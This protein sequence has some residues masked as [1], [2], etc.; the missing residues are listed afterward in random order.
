MAR[1]N[2]LS[3]IAS[4]IDGFNGGYDTV[5]KV[6]R[7]RD[8]RQVA[9]AKPDES[10]GMLQEGDQ[11][12]VQAQLDSGAGVGEARTLASTGRA[13]STFS[14]LGQ[15]Q[16]TPF[17][18][19]QEGRAR[20]LAQ[21]GVMDKHGD[22]EGALRLRG[23][24]RQEARADKQAARDDQRFAWEQSAQERAGRAA[25]TAE[26]DQRLARDT[27]TQVGEWFKGRLRNPDGTERPPTVD[28]HLAASQHRAS[29][30][31]SAGKPELAAKT[32]AEHN[33]Q[34]LLKIQMET[35]ARNEAIGKTAAALG[36][37]DLGAVRDFYNAHVPD[38]ARVTDVQRGKNGEIVIQRET[39]AGQPMPPTMLKD[40]GQ[41]LAALNSFKDPMALYNWSQ[42]EFKR[43]LETRADVRADRADSRAGAAAGRAAAEFGAEAPQREAK[44]AVAKL[45]L[46]L[47]NTE[48]PVKAQAIEKKLNA[49]RNGTRSSGAAADPAHVREAQSMVAAGMVP[50]MATGLELVLTKPDQTH[51]AFVEMGLK[52]MLKPE[53]AVRQADSTMTSMGWNKRGS[54]WSKADG[55]GG[56]DLPPGVAKPASQSAAHT[57]AASAV[58]KGA[59]KD[60][61]NARLKR[62]GFPPL[63]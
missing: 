22:I 49:L 25:E 9:E 41:M 5:G 36:A 35:A 39:L 63:P 3:Q 19:E 18:P 51:K 40:T 4:L 28:D 46:E 1:R 38:G 33:A 6:M 26:A 13:P 50:D 31:M 21:A 7:D 58:A 24:V 44:N 45:T 32:M 61:V 14:L 15:T 23:N 34:A 57:E 48:D 17:T 37:G 42:S 2:R 60:V 30:L 8:L 53:E 29:L 47:A 20:M 56:A 43:N 16:S 52:N 59:S 55:A 10:L 27:D 62:L 11:A 12:A 54:R